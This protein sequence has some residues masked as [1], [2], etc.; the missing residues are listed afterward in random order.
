[1]AYDV[2]QQLFPSEPLEKQYLA[3]LV[4]W[5]VTSWDAVLQLAHCRCQRLSCKVKGVGCNLAGWFHGRTRCIEQEGSSF[6]RWS[7]IISNINK[8]QTSLDAL[9]RLFYENC[10]VTLLYK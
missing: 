6:S 9:V 7:K 10:H 3:R 4:L 1:M 2:V 5:L 8:S